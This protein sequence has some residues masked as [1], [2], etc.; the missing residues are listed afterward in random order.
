MKQTYNSIQKSTKW[1][2]TGLLSCLSLAVM[3]LTSCSSDNEEARTPVANVTVSQQHLEINQS[4]VVTFQGVADQVVVYT[5]DEGHQYTLRSQSNTGFV[6]NKGLFT[7]SYSVPGTFHV[8]VVATTY[9]TFNG[10]GLRNDTTAFDVVV[11]DDVTTLDRVYSSI[12]PNVYYADALDEANW[13][14]RLPTKQ[15]YSGREVALNATRQR[16][17]FDIASD[18]SKIVVD[19]AAWSSKN[20]YDLTKTHS[21]R[22]T[23]SSGT[24]R[25]YKLYGIIYPEFSAISLAGVNGKLVRDAFNQDV[26]T[27]TF[28]LPAGTDLSSVATT[29]TIDGTGQFFV[30][31]KAVTSGDKVDFSKTGVYTLVRTHAENAAV[32]ATT[33]INIV[34]NQ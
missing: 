11:T 27:Y 5:G 7:Y 20:Y 34:I 2:L 32:T 8:V 3:T 17:S 4:M 9:D 13:V 21:I 30:D 28:T 12:T 29:F 33:K 22:V 16:L 1:A 26:L 14:L 10:E 6:M 19:E 31:G 18:S 25:D 23:S 24:V 15:V